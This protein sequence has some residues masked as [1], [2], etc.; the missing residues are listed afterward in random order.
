MH[1]YIQ[2][3]YMCIYNTHTCVHAYITQHH[4]LS[5]PLDY[6]SDKD[7]DGVWLTNVSLVFNTIF[8]ILLVFL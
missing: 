4:C 5:P 6:K 2:Y 8:F 3:R 7:K 1:A